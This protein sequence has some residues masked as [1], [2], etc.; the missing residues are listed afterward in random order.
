MGLNA[1]SVFFTMLRLRRSHKPLLHGALYPNE[2]AVDFPFTCSAS[3]RKCTLACGCS[4]QPWTKLCEADSI[5]R[6]MEYVP[7]RSKVKRTAQAM[8]PV[9][10]AFNALA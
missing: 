6:Q 4:R 8:Q 7:P 10:K 5:T 2:N 9:K 3:S 1:R